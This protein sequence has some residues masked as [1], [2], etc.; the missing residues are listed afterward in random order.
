[1]PLQATKKIIEK[2]GGWIISSIENM[3]EMTLFTFKTFMWLFRPPF[4]IRI[5]LESME[6]VGFGSLFIVILTGTFTGLVMSLQSINAF[7]LF[8]AETLV[9]ATVA[10]AM[11]RELSPVLTSL[12]V[13]GRTGS[14]MATE[15]G[16]MRVTEQIDAMVAMAVDPIQY[17]VVPRVVA[18]TIMMPL[19]VMLFNFVGMVGAYLMAVYVMGIDPGAYLNRIHEW[20][21]PMDLIS[22]GIKAV[23]F[24]MTIS[25]IGCYKGYN[26]SGGAKGVG[27]ATTGAVVAGSVMTL[28]LDYFLTVIM[29]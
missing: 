20:M 12:M 17:L 27:E 1:M 13:T 3:G 19:L 26:A 15:L 29:W 14:A 24:G 4:R 18:T 2:G 5:F 16:T 11:S 28:V 25:L 9:G 23:V 21:Q 10:L 22:G 8:N 6:F 7:Q